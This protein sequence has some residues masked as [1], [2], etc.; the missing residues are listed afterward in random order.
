MMRNILPILL[1]IFIVPAHFTEQVAN[2]IP[3]THGLVDQVINKLVDKFFDRAIN[4]WTEGGMGRQGRLSLSRTLPV[5]NRPDVQRRPGARKTGVSFGKLLHISLP[6][7]SSISPIFNVHLGFQSGQRSSIL[8]PQAEGKETSPDAINIT[9]MEEVMRVAEDT[10]KVLSILPAYA[11]LLIQKGW[12]Y[13][14]VRPPEDCAQVAV[15]DAIEVPAFIENDDGGP[16]GLLRKGITFGTVGWFTGL[17]AMKANPNFMAEVLEKV[18]RE[19]PGIIVACQTGDRSQ[20]AAEL[21]LQ[22][23]YTR[24]AWLV[25]GFDASTPGEIATVDGTDIRNAGKGGISGFFDK[26]IDSQKE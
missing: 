24:L 10:G 16:A 17:K 9:K 7:G 13:L 15:K 11:P 2:P 22:S 26:I 19:S 18:D 1:F 5:I 25:G 20:V 4:I 21:L 23:G 6:T 14:D 8:A 3:C 12:I